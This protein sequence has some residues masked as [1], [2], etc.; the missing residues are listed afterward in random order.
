MKIRTLVA[1]L[2]VL[3]SCANPPPAKTVVKDVIDATK[4]ACIFEQAVNLTD[5]AAI[6]EACQIDASLVPLLDQLLAAH[7]AAVAKAVVKAV[8]ACAGS[9]KK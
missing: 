6:A 1:A 3:A 5:S 8:S 2:V 7:R 4:Y 9:P